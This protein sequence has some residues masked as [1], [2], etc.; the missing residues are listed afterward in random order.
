MTGATVSH[1]RLVSNLNSLFH[2]HVSRSSCDVFSNDMKIKI[3]TLDTYYYPDLIVTCE[4]LS[5]KAVY[6]TAPRLIVE[7]LSPST[8]SID[9]REKLLAYRS[10]ESLTEYVLVDQDKMQIEIYGKEETG[11]WER[12]QYTSKDAVEFHSLPGGILRLPIEDIYKR[13]EFDDK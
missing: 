1:N 5:P 2:A 3:G 8:S 13:V 4:K 7:I 12:T 11:T 9:R 10:I 6:V